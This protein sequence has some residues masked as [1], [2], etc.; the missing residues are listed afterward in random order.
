VAFVHYVIPLPSGPADGARFSVAFHRTTRWLPG[1]DRQARARNVIFSGGTLGTLE[2][3]FKCRE[4]TRTLPRISP[5]LGELVRSNSEA[6]LGAMSPDRQTDYS[7]GVAIT[8]IF[9]A[10]ARTAVEPVR[11]SSGSSLIRLISAPVIQLHN[12]FL[13]R[14]FALLGKLVTHPRAFLRSY[15][16]PG[17]AN[18]TTILLA[19]QTEDNH[20]T[21]RLGRNWLTLFKRSLVSCL[22][23]QNPVPT[24]IEIGHAITGEFTRRI[25]GDMA[26]SIVEVLFDTPITAHIL[27]GVSFGRDDQEGVI[28]LDCQVH[29]YPGLYVVDGSIV[30]ANPGVNPSLTITALAE[31][32][33]SMIPPRST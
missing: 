12:S 26:G 27:G 18:Y 23:E 33:M 15:L 11:Y 4:A 21:M 30:P 14:L 29:N 20:L 31:Y 1:R 5:H 22:A 9:Q 6:L 19:M 8:S 17:W 10:D 2:L 32:A 24:R 28:G 25:R 7:K 13:G 16:A 3:L